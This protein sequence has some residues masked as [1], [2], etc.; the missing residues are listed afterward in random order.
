MKNLPEVSLRK[1]I[2]L[3]DQPKKLA[4]MAVQIGTKIA[5]G[6]D[7]GV[8]PHGQNANEFIEYVEAGMTPM[9]S[10]VAGTSDAAEAGGIKG[11]GKLEP[12]MAADVVAMTLSPLKDIHAVQ[13]VSF[14][15]RDG[16]IFKQDGA[17]KPLKTASADLVPDVEDAF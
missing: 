7:A 10:L 15:M 3:G 2:A 8:Y 9:Q 5:L 12:G 13:N 1:V 14:V 17:E 11:V 4:R 16:I 6:T